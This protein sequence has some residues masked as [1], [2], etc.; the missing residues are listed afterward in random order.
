MGCKGCKKKSL[1]ESNGVV[2]SINKDTHLVPILLIIYT[3]LAVY[4]IISLILDIKNL[5][6]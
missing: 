5:F 1:K 3:L 6:I 4:G 2:P